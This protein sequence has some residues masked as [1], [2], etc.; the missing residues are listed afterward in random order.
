MDKNVHV[1]KTVIQM[2]SLGAQINAKYDKINTFY[3]TIH[4]AIQKF[5]VSTFVI[6]FI[7]Y[8]WILLFRRDVLNA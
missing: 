7:F 8:K 1:K 5:G 4:N 6:F 2:W 3:V